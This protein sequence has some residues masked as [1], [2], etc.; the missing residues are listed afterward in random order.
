[1][2]K[3]NLVKQFEM[4]LWQ[5]EC[6]THPALVQHAAETPFP[7]E[8]YIPMPSREDSTANGLTR[9]IID[10]IKLRGGQAERV[11]IMGRP[12]KQANG[13][14]M[15]GKSHMTKGTAD[16]SATICGR[17]VKIEV[18]IGAD[19]QSDAQRKY[20]ADIERAGGM[21]YIAKD[22]ESFVEWYNK[23]FVCTT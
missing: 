11:S 15:F 16:I 19:R 14:Y 23:T 13:N 3:S 17:S 6:D 9:C 10:F 7:I 18:K 22:F 8:A 4:E 20:Q 2:K 5:H 12:I 1:M 21:Y